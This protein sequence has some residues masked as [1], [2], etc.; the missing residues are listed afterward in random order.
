MSA[1]LLETDMARARTWFEALRDDICAAFETLEA[2]LPAGR[3]AG[4]LRAGP[5][6]AHALEP[7]RS[8]RRATDL[9]CTRDRRSAWVG[10]GRPGRRRH[11]VDH[12][13]PRVREGWR[14]RVDRVRRVRAGI[15]QGHPGS[16][17]RSALLGLG[18][19][20]AHLH[21]PHVPAVHMNTRLVSTS[22]AWFGGGAD[23]TPVLEARRRQDDPD[24]IAFTPRCGRRATPMRAWRPM[25]R[26]SN[27]AMNISTSSIATRCAASAAS[28]TTISTAATAP[29]TSPSRRT[30]AAPS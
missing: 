21:N 30:S 3:A 16:R 11:D 8:R 24:T 4:R 10:W 22:K 19:S 13:R 25:R 5:L 23:L 20:I 7:Y 14:A 6:R 28:S 27:G 1:S 2:D 15:P 18:I 29:P 12:E 17:N 26:P 9:G